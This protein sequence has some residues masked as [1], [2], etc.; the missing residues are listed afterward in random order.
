MHGAPAKWPTGQR[1]L[2]RAGF[3]RPA[4]LRPAWK[5]S[6]PVRQWD[7]SLFR[8]LTLGQGGRN[9]LDAPSAQKTRGFP[10]PLLLS[11]HYGRSFL[12]DASGKRRR[13]PRKR[14]TIGRCGRRKGSPG[15]SRKFFQRK[16]APR[17]FPGLITGPGTE[18]PTSARKVHTT[19]TDPC[20]TRTS[21]TEG[22]GMIG[23]PMARPWPPSFLGVLGGSQPHQNRQPGKVQGARLPATP[24][25]PVSS[26]QEDQI[27]R[28]G[29]STGFHRTP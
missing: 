13:E 21:P 12:R 8:I 19:P 14:L 20:I 25:K 18:P 22:R 23:A 5:G 15:T 7:R 27:R 17:L 6:G 4:G 26:A 1:V 9:I 3:P 24:S 16:K 10:P 11:K 2:C 29:C 28:A